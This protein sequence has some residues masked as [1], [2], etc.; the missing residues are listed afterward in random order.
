M[1]ALRA[2]KALP[3]FSARSDDFSEITGG[4]K[5][6]TRSPACS[7][8]NT[9]SGIAC[10]DGAGTMH[11]KPTSNAAIVAH[12]TLP[13]CARASAPVEKT[14]TRHP[15]QEPTLV[16]PC[17]VKPGHWLPPQCTASRSW[18]LL[19]KACQA[20]SLPARTLEGPARAR[21]A[22]VLRRAPTSTAASATHSGV[23]L[24]TWGRPGTR[25]H[26]PA[27]GL[28]CCWQ[29]RTP[30]ARTGAPRLRPPPDTQAGV[31]CIRAWNTAPAATKPAR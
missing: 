5:A 27:S 10:A 28:A 3:I 16:D 19:R 24:L 4:A 6:S 26:G 11:P 13:T 23:L 31:E 22:G 15:S 8:R 29:A 14:R 7:R 9:S 21:E 1:I 20:P 25:S 2:D 12:V 30:V 17:A 18:A